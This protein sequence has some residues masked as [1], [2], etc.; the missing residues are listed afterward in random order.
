MNNT[1]PINSKI[2]DYLWEVSERLELVSG[3]YLNNEKSEY[4]QLN[5]EHLY[6]QQIEKAKLL[7]PGSYIWSVVYDWIS[8]YLW[9]PVHNE[10]IDWKDVVEWILATGNILFLMDID[11]KKLKSIKANRYYRSG[12]KEYIVSVFEEDEEQN[13]LNHQKNYYLLVESYKSPIFTRKLYKLNSSD[14]YMFWD[15]V[16]LSTLAI[17]KGKASELTIKNLDSLVYQKEIEHSLLKKIKTIIHSIDGK[18]MEADKNF[19]QYTEQFKIFRNLVIPDNCY[20]K[21]ENG[22][23]VIDFDKLWKVVQTNDLQWSVWGLEIVKNTNQLLVDSLD[24][25]DKQIR[26]ISSITTI[27]LFAFWI[28]QESG[29]DSGTSK[30]KSAGIFYKKIEKYRDFISQWFEYFWEIFSVQEE[31]RILKWNAI[32]TTDP[33]EII[34]N[35]DTKLANGTTSRKR[36][37]MKQEWVDEEQAEII[38]QEILKENLLFNP[39]QNDWGNSTT[40]NKETTGERHS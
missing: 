3:D 18:L 17:T 29:Q 32:T 4:F 25:I 19:R 26:Q 28:K 23:Q 2:Q 16:P 5:V 21:L 1:T 15:E 7:N 37:I 40:K 13:I 33:K 34:E 9:I 38:L 12:S 6:P 8:S 30:I 24:F 39:I 14:S 22:V 31:K 35:E 10:N 36:A 11:N 27:P 20:K